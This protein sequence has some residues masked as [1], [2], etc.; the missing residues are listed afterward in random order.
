MTKTQGRK[1]LLDR[2]GLRVIAVL[3]C[4]CVCVRMGE[5]VNEG[6]GS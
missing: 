2:T 5:G 4:V 3:L 6:E 1:S